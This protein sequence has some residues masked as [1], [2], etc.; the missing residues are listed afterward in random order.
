METDHLERE[1]K[2]EL[3]RLEK[4]LRKT[5]TLRLMGWAGSIVGASLALSSVSDQI[6][7]IVAI[8]FVG[9]LLNLVATRFVSRKTKT[10]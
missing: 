8:A 4:K 10:R 7:I 9:A 1:L 6:P 3:Q 5:E 2:T